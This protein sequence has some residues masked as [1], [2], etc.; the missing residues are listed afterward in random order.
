[1]MGSQNT[2]ASQGGAWKLFGKVST[3]FSSATEEDYSEV[4]NDPDF[5]QNVLQS[6][7]GVDPNSDDIQ[8]AMS[9]LTKKDDD[10][11]KEDKK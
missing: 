10:K 2:D 1:M 8:S 5:I 7:P 4:M 6:L 3:N 11:K 9:S